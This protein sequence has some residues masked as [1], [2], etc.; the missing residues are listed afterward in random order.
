[1]L[2]AREELA[3]LYGTMGRTTDRLQQLEALLTFDPGPRAKW[4]SDLPISAP[5]NSIAR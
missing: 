4:R 2:H 5:G 3:D 1:M